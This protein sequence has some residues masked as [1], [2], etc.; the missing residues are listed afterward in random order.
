M[1]CVLVAC[2]ALFAARVLGQLLV[3]IAQ[4][5]WL[6]PMEGWQSGLLPYPVLLG[7]QLLILAAQGVVIADVAAGGTATRRPALAGL[8]SNAQ[9]I[10]LLAL[11]AVY[12]IGMAYRTAR[13]RRFDRPHWWSRGTIPIV[14]HMVLA[15]FLASWGLVAI[16]AA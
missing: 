1:T 6:P 3:V 2:A 9:G 4:P 12:V 5:R 11:A 13:R 8:D 15:T 10:A 14:F 16:S 7:S